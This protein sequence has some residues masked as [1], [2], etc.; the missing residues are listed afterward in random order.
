M[1]TPPWI[2]ALGV[3]GTW[4]I[5]VA[6]I[7]GDRIRWLLFRPQLRVALEN[8]RGERTI[9][10]IYKAPAEPNYDRPAR[11]YRLVASNARRWSI[12]HDV[13]ILITNL[14]VPDASGLPTPVWTGEIPLLWLHGQVYPASRNLGRPASADFVII[15]QDLHVSENQHQLHLMPA[16]LPNNFQR[17]YYS[18]MHIW[19]TVVATSIET[20]SPPLRLAVDWDGA[21]EEGEAEMA[22]HFKIGPA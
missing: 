2:T 3:V 22:R 13:R 16:I 10:T 12:A 11:Y 18:A 5:F 6:A 8:P 21:W 14:E 7:W 1:G 20:D 17:S 9:E 15:A 4:L 19:V